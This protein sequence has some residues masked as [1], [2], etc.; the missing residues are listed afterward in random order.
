M[1]HALITALCIVLF[2]SFA[3]GCLWIMAGAVGVAVVT[4][5]ID[6][7]QN[8]DSNSTGTEAL[9][10]YLA[11]EKAVDDALAGAE[12]E[13]IEVKENVTIDDVINNNDGKII[14]N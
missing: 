13:K 4:A 6:E 5:N 10:E 1:K 12:S 2:S 11:D 8:S 7:Y 14:T 9:D 3:S